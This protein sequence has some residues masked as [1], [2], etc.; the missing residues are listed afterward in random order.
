MDECSLCAIVQRCVIDLSGLVYN[1]T[2]LPWKYGAIHH[3]TLHERPHF[4]STQPCTLISW[5]HVYSESVYCP[6]VWLPWVYV[7]GQAGH[8]QTS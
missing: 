5:L 1:I 4:V 7:Q 2:W 3:I 6:V 8:A